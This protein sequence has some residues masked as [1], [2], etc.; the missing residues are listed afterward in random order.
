MKKTAKKKIKLSFSPKT[1]T[2]RLLSVLPERSQDVL[3]RRYGLGKSTERMTLEAIGQI[4]GVTRE[5]VRQIEN[6]ALNTIRK[7][8][9]YDKESAT[10]SEVENVINGMGA[11]VREDEFL[12]EAG[13]D[14][15]TKNHLHFLL[16]LGHPFVYFKE[17]GDFY[18]RW[19]VDEG[20]AKQVER[21]L[22]NLYESLSDDELVSEAKIVNMFLDNLKDLSGRYR[23]QEILRRWLSISKR[24]GSNELGD[25]GRAESPLVSPRG[26][27]DYAYLVI[28]QHGSPMHFSEVAKRISE[29]F[30][31]EA[32]RA[33]THN[34]L[35]KDD[36]FVLVG[37]GL[38]ALNDWG[39]MKGVVRDVIASVLDQYGPLSK[40]EIVDKVLKER[41]VKH[42]TIAVNLQDPKFKRMKD[43]RYTLA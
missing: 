12:N 5:R 10:L 9:I 25:W 4:Y 40:E 22:Q 13:K 35:I 16:V 8:D 38:Y 26:V 24:I 31:K 33:T 23:D 39:Y 15:S 27:R 21:A 29:L 36:R 7:D 32:H 1:V 2:K 14:E 3:T 11:I 37:R 30:E 20:V 17:S 41:Y 6:H 43:G 42:N 19:H 18:H 28:S 34:E